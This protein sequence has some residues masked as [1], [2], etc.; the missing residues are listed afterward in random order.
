MAVKT[1]NPF[2]PERFPV[3]APADVTIKPKEERLATKK[4]LDD[5]LMQREIKS[6]SKDVWDDR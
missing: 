2:H 4:R 6:K 5:Y 3:T 1:T